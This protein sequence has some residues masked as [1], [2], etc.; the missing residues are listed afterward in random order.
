MLLAPEKLIHSPRLRIYC[1]M[2]ARGGVRL[3]DDADGDVVMAEPLKEDTRWAEKRDV[4]CVRMHLS[5][6]LVFGWSMV[7]NQNNGA[8]S[9]VNS[10]GISQHLVRW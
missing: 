3:M 4:F 6:F 10:C 2:L 7:N 9:L 5:C 1:Q 8:L